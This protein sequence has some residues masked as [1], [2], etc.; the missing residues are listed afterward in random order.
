MQIDIF[1]CKDGEKPKKLD[2]DIV[3]DSKNFGNSLA[4]AI[5][6]ASN[7]VSEYGVDLNAWSPFPVD[8]G[9]DHR[10]KCKG[11]FLSVII[12]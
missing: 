12:R 1:L 3:K 2:S 5:A 9:E 6:R 7:Y 10:F 11:G 8:G 4:V